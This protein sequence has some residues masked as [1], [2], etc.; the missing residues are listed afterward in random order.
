MSSSGTVGEVILAGRSFALDSH[1][2]LCVVTQPR[3]LPRVLQHL[4]PQEVTSH[5]GPGLIREGKEVHG[6]HH[7]RELTW[8]GFG[9]VPGC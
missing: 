6:G 4:E 7:F 9:F 3:L 5:S 8:E 2:V 1:P